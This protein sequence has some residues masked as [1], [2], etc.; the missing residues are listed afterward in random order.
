[1][2]AVGPANL[3]GK[4]A[5]RLNE[6]QHGLIEGLD[7]VLITYHDPRMD[8]L[9]ELVLPSLASYSSRTPA[10]M[11]GADRP[12]FRRSQA[13]AGLIDSVVAGQRVGC[14]RSA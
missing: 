4:E 9:Q 2:H 5:N 10:R 11:V 12:D 14:R 6:I 1:V 7:E 8:V 13:H 3:I